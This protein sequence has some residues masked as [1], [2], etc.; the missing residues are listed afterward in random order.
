MFPSLTKFTDSPIR[1][2]YTNQ[3]FTPESSERPSAE[4]FLGKPSG[5]TPNQPDV[6]LENKSV[7]T[8]VPII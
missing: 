3:Y 5:K 8:S 7:F 6:N 1:L 4:D 2:Q